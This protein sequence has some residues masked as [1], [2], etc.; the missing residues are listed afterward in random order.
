MA[1]YTAC[2]KKL[3]FL[4]KKFRDLKNDFFPKSKKRFSS[5]PEWVL[6]LNFQGSSSKKNQT[7]TQTDRRAKK[8]KHSFFTMVFQQTDVQ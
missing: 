1:S 5:I 6:N 8:E 7:H 2:P 4:K 3:A